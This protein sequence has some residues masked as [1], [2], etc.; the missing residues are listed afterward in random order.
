[1]PTTR[2]RAAQDESDEET[3]E[4]AVE[5]VMDSGETL[6]DF[7]PEVCCATVGQSEQPHPHLTTAKHGHHPAVD[8]AM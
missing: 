4:E 5:A 2:R 7:F 3:T 8:T 6:L 1:M